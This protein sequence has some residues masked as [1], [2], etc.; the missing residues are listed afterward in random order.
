MIYRRRDAL[1]LLFSWYQPFL[2]SRLLLVCSL[3][4]H[5]GLDGVSGL[6]EYLAIF[7]TIIF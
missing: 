4:L 5:Y 7:M 6:T 1:L 3:N 2:S